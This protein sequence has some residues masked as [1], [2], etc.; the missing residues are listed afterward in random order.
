MREQNL[1]WKDVVRD[2][3]QQLG[4]QAHLSDINEKVEG[5]PKAANNPHGKLP[6]GG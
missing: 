5:H 6:S 4:G 1:T 3:L 2:A